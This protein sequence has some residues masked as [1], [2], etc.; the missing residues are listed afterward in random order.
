MLLL[1]PSKAGEPGAE[2][3]GS[4][5]AG[6]CAVERPADLAGTQ[7]KLAGTVAAGL[8]DFF[9]VPSQWIECTARPNEQS[10]NKL[11][12]TSHTTNC[13]RDEVRDAAA[14]QSCKGHQQ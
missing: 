7:L 1:L 6:P 13:T 2:E 12:S 4:G 10:A 11:D 8:L 14:H 5:R 9:T 3:H